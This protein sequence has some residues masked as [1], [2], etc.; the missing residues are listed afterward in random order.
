MKKPAEMFSVW[1]WAVLLRCV[2][3]TAAIASAATAIAALTSS[4][5]SVCRTQKEEVLLKYHDGT[6]GSFCSL[7]CAFGSIAAHRGKAV[8]GIMMREHAGETM[9]DAEKA[10]WVLGGSKQGVMSIR[11]KWAF[12]KKKDAEKF[13]RRFGGAVTGFPEALQAAF[14]DMWEILK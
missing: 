6:S 5:C 3:L 2:L 8:V 7:R 4:P 1:P 14:E 11:G 12:E 9:I 10:V 13:I